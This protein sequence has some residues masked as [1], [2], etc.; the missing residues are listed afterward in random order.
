MPSPNRQAAMSA[1]A[2][3]LIFLSILNTGFYFRPFLFIS[4]KF[5]LSLFPI[6]IFSKSAL[7]A[8]LVLLAASF[9]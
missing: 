1:S 4:K 6:S 8:L 7:F 9:A 2:I 3:I 5:S